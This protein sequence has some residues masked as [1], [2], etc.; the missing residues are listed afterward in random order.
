MS[1]TVRDTVFNYHLKRLEP[2]LDGQV[3]GLIID[4][5][6]D[7]G[8]PFVGFQIKCPNGDVV[9]VVA[10]RDE[11]GNGAGHLAIAKIKTNGKT[12]VG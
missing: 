2:L 11:E 10:L 3:V 7:Y 1:D 12:T 4:D 6:A 5:S 9:E 8:S